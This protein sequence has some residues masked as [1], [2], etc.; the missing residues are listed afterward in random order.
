MKM[1]GGTFE[2]LSYVI[3]VAGE[4]PGIGVTNAV[5]SMAH[6][7]GIINMIVLLLINLVMIICTGKL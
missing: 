1:G 3:Q 6:F 2:K 7:F 5:M 4:K